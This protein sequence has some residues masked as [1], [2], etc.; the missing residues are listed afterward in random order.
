MNIISAIPRIYHMISENFQFY[1]NSV[2]NFLDLEI[3]RISRQELLIS[4][5]S[6]RSRVTRSGYSAPHQVD[7]LGSISGGVAASVAR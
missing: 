1:L 6:V 3:A 4:S 7:T 2:P 5:S